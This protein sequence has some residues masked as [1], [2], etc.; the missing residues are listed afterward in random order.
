MKKINFKD[1]ILF[2]DDNYIVVNKPPY[3][4]TLE[5]R[6]SPINILDIARAYNPDIQICHRLD[7]ETSGALVIAKNSEAYRNIAMQFEART[8][9]KVYHAVVD[10][11][12]NLEPVKVSAPILLLG[13]GK[14]AVSFGQ[15]KPSET[16]V[17]TSQTYKRH[18]LVECKPL[19]GRMHQ[20]RIH[21]KYLGAP[22]AGDETYGG[23]KILLSQLKKRFNLTKGAEEK[24]LCERVALHA[25]SV[26]FKN[27]DESAVFIEAPYPKDFDVLIKQL[28]KNSR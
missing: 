13:K 9:Q 14:V 6:T 25:Y 7:K 15:G 11:I 21:M 20:I 12:H 4:S 24:P 17:R 3:I 26:E 28:E 22:L 8:V 27:M 2:E 1:I 19:T 23:K 10:G 18:T 5:D 16:L